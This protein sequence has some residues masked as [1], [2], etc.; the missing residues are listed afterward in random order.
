MQG[1]REYGKRQQ[2]INITNIEQHCSCSSKTSTLKM[3]LNT[4]HGVVD[5]DSNFYIIFHQQ[6]HS[7]KGKILQEKNN[8]E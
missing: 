2:Y 1:I 3:H 4:I 8:N 5:E 6:I 7:K